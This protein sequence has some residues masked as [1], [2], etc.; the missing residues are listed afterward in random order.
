MDYFEESDFLLWLQ[1]KSKRKK[2]RRKTVLMDSAG[3]L[4]RQREI[5][6]L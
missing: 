3:I 1:S 5:A 4:N 6:A 2:Q